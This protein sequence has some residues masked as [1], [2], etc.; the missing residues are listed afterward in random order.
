MSQNMKRR[1]SDYSLTIK[2][3]MNPLAPV[4][5]FIMN[6]FKPNTDFINGQ[7]QPAN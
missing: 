3:E 4:E 5:V 6:L 1:K 7:M 2:K